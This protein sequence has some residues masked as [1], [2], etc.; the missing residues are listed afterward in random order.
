[1]TKTAATQDARRLFGRLDT[2]GAEV[3]AVEQERLAAHLVFR[4]HDIREG[5]VLIGSS[6][7]AT[8]RPPVLDEIPRLIHP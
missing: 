5:P 1:M 2:L 4:E 8:C 7:D 3:R 6:S